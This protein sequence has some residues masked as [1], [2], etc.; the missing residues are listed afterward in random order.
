MRIRVLP[1]WKGTITLGPVEMEIDDEDGAG[2]KAEQNARAEARHEAVLRGMEISSRR[3]GKRNPLLPKDFEP[4]GDTKFEG[5]PLSRWWG[6]QVEGQKRNGTTVD[7]ETPESWGDFADALVV[8]Q[9]DFPDCTPNTDYPGTRRWED[10]TLNTAEGEDRGQWDIWKAAMREALWRVRIHEEAGNY[11]RTEIG[12]PNPAGSRSTTLPA[13]FPLD[14]QLAAV[15]K[16][17]GFRR[18][19][20]AAGAAVFP[21][22][23]GQAHNLY[24]KCEPDEVGPYNEHRP[25]LPPLKLLGSFPTPVFNPIKPR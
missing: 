8:F 1:G 17:L 24:M 2:W 13:L 5:F 11:D 12:L 21:G 16:L 9:R 4:D 20:E 15:C 22:W 6:W 3:D 14:P 10:T 25:D 23:D 7:M 18:L 19:A